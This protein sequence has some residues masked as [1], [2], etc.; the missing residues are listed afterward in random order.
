M[1]QYLIKNLSN[2]PREAYAYG[3]PFFSVVV[4]DFFEQGYYNLTLPTGTVWPKGTMLYVY[5]ISSTIGARSL[6]KTAHADFNAQSSQFLINSNTLIKPVLSVRLVTSED[7]AHQPAFYSFNKSFSFSKNYT[8]PGFYNL[9]ASFVCNSMTFSAYTTISVG[10]GNL[11][12]FQLICTFQ[13]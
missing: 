2:P 5:M 3:L 11:F 6:S 4:Q 13:I 10:S 9:S 1:A 7:L 12:A 8:N